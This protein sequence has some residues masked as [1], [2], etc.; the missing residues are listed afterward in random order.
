MNTILSMWPHHC[1]LYNCNFPIWSCFRQTF[2]LMFKFI[3][4]VFIALL[5]PLELLWIPEGMAEVV[6]IFFIHWSSSQSWSVSS[7]EM[8]EWTAWARG[9]AIKRFCCSHLWRPTRTGQNLQ[10]IKSWLQDSAAGFFWN[11][12]CYGHRNGQIWWNS[13]EPVKKQCQHSLAFTD[14]SPHQP[15]LTHHQPR[16]YGWAM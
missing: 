7:G 3:S 4:N 10:R 8:S 2:F 14:G 13:R 16:E 12:C 5:I 11:R 6:L 1:I 9:H 15:S